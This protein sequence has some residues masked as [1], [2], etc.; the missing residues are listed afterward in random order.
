MGTLPQE[1]KERMERL[2]GEEYED[3][4][5]SWE[6]EAAQALRVNTLKIPSEEFLKLARP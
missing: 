4:S 5:K 1:F 6:R 3:F 2:L